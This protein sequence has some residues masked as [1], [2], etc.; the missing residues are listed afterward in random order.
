MK[1]AIALHLESL[2]TIGTPEFFLEKSTIP[3]VVKFLEA[4]CFVPLRKSSSHLTIFK[5]VYVE[6]RPIRNVMISLPIHKAPDLGSKLTLKIMKEAGCDA[7]NFL[8]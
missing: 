6:E 7:K 1:E 2:Q 5:T 3:S 4:Q 8:K